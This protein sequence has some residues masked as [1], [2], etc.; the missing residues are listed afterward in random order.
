MGP[1][2]KSMIGV[3]RVYAHQRYCQET[4]VNREFPIFCQKVSPSKG[5]DEGD[6]AYMVREK[7]GLDEDP[8]VAHDRLKLIEHKVQIEG[9][10][11]IALGEVEYQP[12]PV[13]AQTPGELELF[14]RIRKESIQKFPRSAL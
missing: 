4:G 7:L 10:R 13:Y 9:Y 8:F 6:I 1:G 3:R 14:E 5:Y 11:R 12:A 2:G